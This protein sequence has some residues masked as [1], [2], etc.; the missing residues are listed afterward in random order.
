M[1]EGV[2]KLT[3]QKETRKGELKMNM[4]QKFKWL[5]DND[6]ETLYELSVRL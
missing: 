3:N 4:I 1:Q 2:K 5:R 6:M